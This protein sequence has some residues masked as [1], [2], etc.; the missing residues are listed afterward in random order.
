M[1]AARV[2]LIVSVVSILIVPSE[3]FGVDLRD[4]RANYISV[5]L[6]QIIHCGPDDISGGYWHA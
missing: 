1:Y 6:L 2:I 3:L 4:Y 5:N